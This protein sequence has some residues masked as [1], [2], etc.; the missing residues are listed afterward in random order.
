MHKSIGIRETREQH[1]EDVLRK[2]SSLIYTECTA[3]NQIVCLRFDQNI[4][5]SEGSTK[6]VLSSVP[7]RHSEIFLA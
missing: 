3:E 1:A 4:K 6:T 5:N 7:H 2:I